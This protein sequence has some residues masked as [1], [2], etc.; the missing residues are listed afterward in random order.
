VKPLL[1]AEVAGIA[2]GQIART[3]VRRAVRGPLRPG[4]PLRTELAQSVMRALLMR[5]KRRGISWLRAAHA[6]SST[7]TAAAS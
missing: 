7:S 2:T 3:L 1:L 4:W 5:S 6:R